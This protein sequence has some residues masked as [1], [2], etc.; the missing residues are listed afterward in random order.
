METEKRKIEKK[1]KVLLGGLK[2]KIHIKTEDDSLPVLLFLHGGPG[3]PDRHGV[4]EANTDL[5]DAFT[6]VAWDQRGSGGSRW[7]A[8]QENLTV[9]R[10]TDDAA[11]LV[12]WLCGT[13]KKDKIFIIGGSWGSVL[14]S[15]L[16]YRYPKKIAAYVGYGQL[17]D[18]AENERLSFEFALTEAKKA[19]DAESV[20]QLLSVGP[21][22][23]GVYK[24]GMSGLLTQRKIMMRYGGHSPKADKEKKQNLVVYFAKS[25]LKS[26][27]YSI[28]DLLGTM[29]GAS[30]VLKNMWPQV[31]GI[32]LA[33]ACPE[34]KMP[35]FIFDGRLDSMTPA[36]LV[37]DYFDRI[38][39][40]HKELHWFGNSGHNPIYE[41][42][43]AFKKL[44]REKLNVVAAAERERGAI[45]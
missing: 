10:F 34:Y 11:E 4:M 40:P 9:E 45:L 5:L 21:P 23:K 43:E 39:A 20:E 16:V 38:K 7:G 17:V 8:K 29:T 13:F 41:E 44:L 3:M 25:L 30:F 28:G 33:E 26:G 24:G 18:G 27:E 22:E 19:G 6:I 36:A 15:L 37:E 31:A 14:G 35:Y 12:D 1:Q 42:P 32:N 2:Q